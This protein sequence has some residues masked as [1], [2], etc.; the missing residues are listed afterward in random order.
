HATNGRIRQI[1]GFSTR[2]IHSVSDNL[3]IEQITTDI[4]LPIIKRE[5]EDKLRQN[6]IT[7]REKMVLEEIAENPGISPSI[8]SS[9][10]SL[11]L[12]NLSRLLS[13]LLKAR[14]VSF[15]RAGRIRRYNVSSDV[16]IALTK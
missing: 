14:F 7:R 3:L 6:N 15:E 4:A 13:H 12:P 16:L 8:L 2:L 1:F 10:I 9:K 11:S 5:V